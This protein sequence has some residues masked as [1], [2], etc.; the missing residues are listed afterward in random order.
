M[1]EN[2]VCAAECGLVADAIR[3]HDRNTDV[4][5]GASDDNLSGTVRQIGRCGHIGHD[6]GP[7]AFFRCERHRDCPRVGFGFRWRREDMQGQN[8]QRK[9]ENLA[10]PAQ[11]GLL[12]QQGDRNGVVRPCGNGLHVTQRGG[13]ARSAPIHP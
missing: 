3:V 6:D 13:H 1:E 9:D 11:S 12:R 5:Q 8:G 2:C 4:K 10:L 7:Y